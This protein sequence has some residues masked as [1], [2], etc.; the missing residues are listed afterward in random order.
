MP[1]VYVAAGSNVE[2]EANLTVAL[3]ALRGHF[4]DLQVSRAYA[5]R[6]V[7]FE[8]PD[9]I[10]LV[11]AFSTDLSLPDVLA[12]LHAVE[13]ACGRGRTAP[14][15]APR[16]MDLDLLLFGD[17]VGE[18]S[19]ATLP[20]PDLLRRAFM[21]GPLAEI[22]PLVRH[23]VLHQHIADLWLAFDRATHDLRPVNVVGAATP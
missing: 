16:R 19:G 18:F 20:R 9:F 13:S 2:P 6:A 14:K 17:L 4:P 22:A 21:L 5:N 23:P 3:A 1:V 7:G 15:W 8:G 10:N 11:A 12:V